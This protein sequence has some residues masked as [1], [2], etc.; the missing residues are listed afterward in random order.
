[1]S[2]NA[3]I[4]PLFASL[5]SSSLVEVNE[6]HS[7]AILAQF[8][9]Y[10]FEIFSNDSTNPQGR[11]LVGINLVGIP[12][13]FLRFFASLKFLSE[14]SQAFANDDWHLIRTHALDIIRHS[15][16]AVKTHSHMMTLLYM[17]GHS[18]ILLKKIRETKAANWF[19]KIS[20][21]TGFKWTWVVSK[22]SAFYVEIWQEVN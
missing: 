13:F 14:N 11:R 4:L 3:A 2:W 16:S 21:S 22:S 9:I 1:M 6:K 19:E 12:S 15:R 7:A 8:M 17:L 10:G 20:S 5:M 18:Q